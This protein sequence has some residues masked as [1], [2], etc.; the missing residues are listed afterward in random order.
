MSER[1]MEKSGLITPTRFFFGAF[2][3]LLKRRCRSAPLFLL[4]GWNPIAAGDNLSNFELEPSG[5]R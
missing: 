1:N 2:W 4:A 3:V 5:V